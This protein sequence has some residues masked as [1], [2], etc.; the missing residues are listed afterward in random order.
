MFPPAPPPKKNTHSHLRKKNKKEDWEERRTYAREL[1]W[2][3]AVIHLFGQPGPTKQRSALESQTRESGRKRRERHALHCCRDRVQR[4]PSSKSS[5]RFGSLPVI[6]RVVP[7]NLRSAER[8]KRPSELTWPAYRTRK[9]EKRRLWSVSSRR[10]MP[11][12]Y[13]YIDDL[14]RHCGK[15]GEAAK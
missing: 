12:P 14:S 15:K 11:A 2:V 7:L 10:F 5:R 1:Q 4:G 3:G 9:R 8:E 6:I 13:L